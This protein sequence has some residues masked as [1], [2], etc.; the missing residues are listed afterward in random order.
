AL[1]I[2]IV[3]V[4]VGFGHK[5]GSGLSIDGFVNTIQSRGRWIVFGSIDLMVGDSIGALDGSFDLSF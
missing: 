3:L 4:A 1:A 2:L 5:W